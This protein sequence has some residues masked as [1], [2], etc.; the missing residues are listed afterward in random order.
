MANEQ[1]SPVQF[2]EFKAPRLLPDGLLNLQRAR[3]EV[4]QD[5]ARA[6]A[7]LGNQV[8]R[9]AD[10]AAAAEGQRAGM[11]AGLREDFRPERGNSIRSRAYDEAGVRNYMLKLESSL[12]SDMFQLYEQHKDDPAGFDSSAAELRKLYERDHVFTEVAGDF[13]AGFERL[14]DAYRKES[15]RNAERRLEDER[16]ASL[17]AVMN[18]A[19]TQTGR[20]IASVEPDSDSGAALVGDALAA[21]EAA[22]D[23]AVEEG[24][25]PAVKAEEL[26]QRRR[27]EAAVALYSRQAETITDLQDLAAYRQGLTEKFTSGELPA[28][29]ADAFEAIDA[30]LVARG[31]RLNE[32]SRQSAT[33]ITKA[34]AAIADRVL[35]GAQVNGEETAALLL[36]G[37]S[38]PNGDVLVAEAFNRISIAEKIRD[39]PLEDSMSML[40]TMQRKVLAGK[41]SPREIADFDFTRK[42]VDDKRRFVL[43]DP[44]GAAAQYGFADRRAADRIPL[45]GSHDDVA[46]LMQLRQEAASA[47]GRQFGVTPRLLRPGEAKEIGR[48]VQTDPNRAAEIAGGLV[49]GAGSYLP[50]LMSELGNDAPELAQ[51]GRIMALGGAPSAAVD[52]FRGASKDGDGRARPRVKATIRNEQ[53]VTGLAMRY[54]PD[55]F[56]IVLGAAENI[57]RARISDAGIDPTDD[58][59]V[60]EIFET[61]LQEAAGRTIGADGVAR[62]GFHTM[63]GG[64]FDGPVR[65]VLIPAEMSAAEFERSF[66]NLPLEPL[67]AAGLNPRY[68]E[69]Q[70]R[71][72]WPVKSALGYYLAHGSED[73]P[74]LLQREDGKPFIL[75]E[76]MLRELSRGMR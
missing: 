59:A 18:D 42:A 64:W 12:R 54:M 72:A 33:A 21:E 19:A 40:E 52:V 30:A 50:N 5:V 7:G 6:F 75:P 24:T 32:G 23:A 29:D 38:A 3:G 17:L 76:A 62:G 44:I 47:A 11:E 61:A 46:A 55:D 48:L 43:S 10:R 22:I 74:Q 67:R 36:A 35:N 31:R 65:R 70:L 2:R 71:K 20:I 60:A 51:A 49:A 57:A 63:G 8:G 45:N 9:M 56:R 4:E 39:L 26:K 28:V 34:G 16:Q 53:A 73:E 68:S 1:R 14:A 41:A 15:G 69:R 66:D 58:D 25:I 37:R 27:R 13:A